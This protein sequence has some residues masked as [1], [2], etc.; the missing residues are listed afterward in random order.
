MLSLIELARL[1]YCGRAPS[2]AF[3]KRYDCRAGRAFRYKS[4]WREAHHCGLSASIPHATRQ[5]TI[6]IIRLTRYV[7]VFASNCTT[8]LWRANQSPFFE[9]ASPLSLPSQKLAMTLNFEF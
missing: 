9:I 4:S 2:T 3:A 7:F 5:L 1:Y 8:F 6:K